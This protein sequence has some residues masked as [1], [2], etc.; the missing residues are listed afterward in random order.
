MKIAFF[1]NIQNYVQLSYKTNAFRG[2]AAECQIIGTIDLKESDYI[3]FC[4]DF[5]RGYSFLLPYV[6]KTII[7]NDIWHGVLVK[8]GDQGVVVVMNGYQYPRYV[9][10]IL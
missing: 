7:T 9:G 4:R 3:D 5:M 6:F 8:C 2:I 1:R 10:Q